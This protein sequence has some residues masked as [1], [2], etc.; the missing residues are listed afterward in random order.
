MNLP[1]LTAAAGL[2]TLAGGLSLV[3]I[4]ATPRSAQAGILLATCGVGLLAA[5]AIGQLLW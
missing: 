5:L 1:H 3:N 2:L 4:L